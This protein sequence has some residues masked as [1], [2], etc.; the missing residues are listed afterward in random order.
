MFDESRYI[1]VLLDVAEDPSPFL[2]GRHD[3]GEVVVG[4][5]V[6]ADALVTSVPVR[7]IPDVGLLQRR[8]IIDLPSPVIATTCSSSLQGRD[9]PQLVGGGDAGED[10][11]AADLP[12]QLASDI[13]S[14]SGPVT[15]R[16][17]RSNPSSLAIASGRHGVIA[18][19]ITGRMPALLQIVIASLASGLGRSCRPDQ[20]QGHG[21]CGVLESCA[22]PG[23]D[24][25]HPQRITGEGKPNL[26]QLLAAFRIEGSDACGSQHM[27]AVGGA[28][29]RARP[30]CMQQRPQYGAMWS[31]VCSRR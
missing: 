3:G 28:A 22:L 4:Q 27:G 14:S 29:S 23:G 19:I 20:A 13:S 2:D 11:D 12:L 16:P 26:G 24:C 15:T 1:R 30:W 6:I 10:V 18:V 17:S 31:S 7:S 21:P 8:G 25:E 9:H 5:H